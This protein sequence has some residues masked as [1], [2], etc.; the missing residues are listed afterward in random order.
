MESTTQAS[1]LGAPNSM[2]RSCFIPCSYIR[3]HFP[4]QFPRSI[5]PYSA[6][7][8]LKGI[9]VGGSNNSAASGF[10]IS[11][12]DSVRFNY[13]FNDVTMENTNPPPPQSEG[14][15]HYSK[16]GIVWDMH[17]TYLNHDGGYSSDRF[18]DVASNGSKGENMRLSD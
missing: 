4:L 13:V 6:F 15:G 8:A 3:V 14:R 1:L 16:H 7:E 10:I 17:L 18:F 9:T 12:N 11:S 5:P 2:N